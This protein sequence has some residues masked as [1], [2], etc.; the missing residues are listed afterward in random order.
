[1]KLQA[2]LLHFAIR[3]TDLALGRTHVDRPTGQSRRAPAGMQSMR[4]LQRTGVP[5]PRG[6]T[7]SRPAGGGPVVQQ[8][9]GAGL[10]AALPPSR[11]ASRAQLSGEDAPAQ[12]PPCPTLKRTPPPAPGRIGSRPPGPPI[13]EPQLTLGAGRQLLS[14]KDALAACPLSSPDYNRRVLGRPPPKTGS[15]K[16]L[17]INGL[18]Y[19]H[20]G[21]VAENVGYLKRVS[22]HDGAS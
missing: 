8:P 9:E 10:R 1:M 3:E 16:T 14:K 6:A 18:E 5:E 17:A 22:W 11:N 2:H 7:R 4:L 20:N 21:E 13:L 15:C 12:A 19:T